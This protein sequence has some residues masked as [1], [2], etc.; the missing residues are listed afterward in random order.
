[1]EVDKKFKT[2]PSCIKEVGNDYLNFRKDGAILKLLFADDPQGKY[3][4]LNN[5][6]FRVYNLFM[7]VFKDKQVWAELAS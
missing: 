7:R 2:V 1:M 3:R 5:V 4:N 6:V